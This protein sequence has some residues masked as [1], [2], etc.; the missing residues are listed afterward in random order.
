MSNSDTR[1]E[2]DKH[3]TT[4]RVVI[5]TGPG[6]T[7]S[8]AIQAWL[9][10]NHKFLAGKGILYPVHP[11]AKSQ[12]SSGNLKVIL[13]QNK[14][15]EA[16]KPG[17]DWF[18]DV[19]KVKVLLEEFYAS[20]AK[21]LL[22]SS[23][24]F[25]HRIVDI[26]KAIPEAEF[27]AYIRNPV[28]LLESNYNQGVKRHGN[29][30]KFSAPKS[31]DKYFWQYLTNVF[32]RVK[33]NKIFLRPY[34]QSLMVGGNIVTDVLAV[35]GLELDVENKRINPSFTF[36]SLEFKRLL[37]YF[38]LGAL[39]PQLDVALQG[40]DLGTPVYSLMDKDD[41][42]RLN[43]QS[44]QAMQ[45]FIEKYQQSHLLP[46]LKNFQ[47]VDQKI[48]RNQNA[49]LR[50]LSA[51]A[52]Y[53]HN[54]TRPLF[55]KLKALVT[56]HQNLLV[57]NPII[58]EVFGVTPSPES[59][60]TEIE[61]NVL[62]HFD[63]FSVEKDKHGH[64]AYQLSCYFRSTQQWESAATF[65]KVAYLFNTDKMELEQHIN[66]MLIQKNLHSNQIHL[67]DFQP[68]LRSKIKRVLKSLKSI[69]KT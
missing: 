37:N 61:Q 38:E 14:G 6:K 3:M 68:T 26:E 17:N 15:D 67:V 65:A 19:E 66:K 53:L 60:L 55:Y 51:I 69:I 49:N 16:L 20:D 42:E 1:I 62:T 50:E 40:C 47:N 52:E 21:V 56:L 46:L 59:E 25:F 22:L 43:K 11:V 13:S 57:D 54:K 58:Y 36:S 8:S 4:K 31:L 48:F 64:I 39:E 9:A 18:V 63:A 7:G 5:H 10:R 34:D 29:I 12:I 44:C 2:N 24:F 23:E 45:I 33:A 28:E 32:K 27:I 35:I 41:F 30:N